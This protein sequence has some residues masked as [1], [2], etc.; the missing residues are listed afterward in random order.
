MPFLWQQKPDMKWEPKGAI[1]GGDN[2]NISVCQK[3]FETQVK[4][5][6]PQTIVNLIDKKGFQL[7]VG[8]YFE[9]M[10]KSC[11][12]EALRYVWFDFHMECR[13]MKYENLSKLVGKIKED[14]EKMGWFQLSYYKS[15][16]FSCEF[17]YYF[18][19]C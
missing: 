7:H 8:E 3:H 14:L 2:E 18:D 10:V 12:N 4:D 13:N 6:G 1:L 15:K 16:V 17:C 5:Y 11:Q 9:K 19:I